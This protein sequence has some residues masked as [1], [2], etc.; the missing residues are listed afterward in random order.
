[1][2]I[3]RNYIIPALIPVILLVFLLLIFN[4]LS[5]FF[6]SWYDPAYAYLM[7]GLTFALGSTDIGHVD[8]PGTP[9]Q[10][11]MALIFR[12]VFLFRTNSSTL[13]DDVLTNPELYLKATVHCLIAINI[14]VLYVFGRAVQHYSG[15]AALGVVAQLAALLSLK[16][17]YHIPIVA[18]ES[19]LMAYS[20][21]LALFAIAL[22]YNTKF[23]SKKFVGIAILS[24]LVLTTKISA[25]PVLALPFALVPTWRKRFSY[26]GLTLLFSL[27]I[28]AP[29][30]QKM[31]VFTGFI[32]RM[33]T[34]S[35]KYGSGEATLINWSEFFDA[36]K[37][38]FTTEWPFTLHFLLLLA[39]WGFVL[40]SKNLNKKLLP[41]L[42][43]L[44]AASLFTV[45]AVG[46]HYSFHYLSPVYVTAMP[47]QVFLWYKLLNYN[48]VRISQRMV[49]IG[50]TAITLFVFTRL[51]VQFHFYP[52][53]TTPVKQTV[54]LIENEYKG[55]YIVL[56]D[57]NNGL[58]LP[59]PALRFGLAYAGSA[60]RMKYWQV[61]ANA[62][63]G[64]FVWN[65]RNGLMNW[66]GVA[67]ST[68]IFSL[69]DTLYLYN[70]SASVNG[71][72]D[73]ITQMI[74]LQ[75]LEPFTKLD[76][77]Y[78]NALSGEV[79]VRSVN[80]TTAIKQQLVPIETIQ[81]SMDKIE[82]SEMQFVSQ[83]GNYYFGGGLQ[84]STNFGHDDQFSIKLDEQNEY[85]L[86][87]KLQVKPGERFKA[88]VWQF[89][90]LGKEAY[91]V[92]SSQNS[93]LYYKTSQRNMVEPRTW[94]L[95]E[96]Q[97][98]IPFDYSDSLLNLYLWLPERE[99][100]WID[101]LRLE[102]FAPFGKG[103]SN[104]VSVQ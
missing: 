68:T 16:S 60:Q 15:K 81:L 58:G 80:Q 13:M 43:G 33:F 82:G 62:Y 71:S 41:L 91:W 1:M 30:W 18:T 8:H 22:H 14:A 83:C 72:Y 50:V 79:I 75:G 61:V 57:G 26:M 76:K 25:L 28:I 12:V 93:S 78:E 27:V 44:T 102:R 9:L 21:L 92:A 11:I 98:E 2:Q 73:R 84:Q 66:E 96:T 59:E 6:Y 86:Q 34:H 89:T 37:M 46:R 17:V 29:V 49:W 20:V 97:F 63:Q 69:H 5:Y 19:L 100:T 3:N 47:L 7:N 32:A 36:L 23:D 55:T 35:G 45:L 51:V 104:V 103:I 53:L 56:A 74:E 64:N 52:N 85:G 99:E 77:V 42:V 24:A 4:E 70:R 94:N 88:S 54:Q 48:E 38:M 87:L 95:S 39:A 65:E 67:M 31:H 101:N 10:L 40:I 90:S